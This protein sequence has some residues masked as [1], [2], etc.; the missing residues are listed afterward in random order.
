MAFFGLFLPCVDVRESD[1]SI[2]LAAGC[3]MGQYVE[4]SEAD[5]KIGAPD[6]KVSRQR[7][8]KLTLK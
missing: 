1:A 4:F 5:G 2:L 6:L 8:V 7:E 3:L